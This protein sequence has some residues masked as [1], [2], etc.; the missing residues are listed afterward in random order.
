[1]AENHN[2]TESGEDSFSYGWCY[3]DRKDG[4]EIRNWY[5]QTDYMKDE[6]FAGKV[7]DM[8]DRLGLPQPD[9]S[10]IFRGSHH[11]LLFLDSHGVVLRIG[12]TDVTDLI[13]PGI[14]QPLGWLEDPALTIKRGGKDVPFTIAIYPGIELL[15]NYL[16]EEEQDRPE[17]VGTLRDIL[18][19]TGQGTRDINRKGNTGVIA[20]TDAHGK[21]AVVEMLLDPDDKYNS[22]DP[23][24]RR[25]KKE[26]FTAAL[27][28]TA[29]K[30]AALAITLSDAFKG[31]KNTR[32]FQKAFQKHQPLRNLF[33]R[34]FKDEKQP[35]EQA[36]T[37]FWTECA[38]V[39]SAPK[40]LA[41]SHWTSTIGEDGKLTVTKTDVMVD[42]VQLQTP[43]TTKISQGLKSKLHSRA[44]SFL[45]KS[46]NKAAKVKKPRR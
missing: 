29:D 3:T 20:I 15:E 27:Q 32:P 34:A 17:M 5:R 21:A 31:A 1:M 26:K 10:E 28:K 36:R 23:Q 19:E 45:H 2:D 11:D 4:K 46:I 38:A 22:S 40:K 35:D 42:H 37:A 24:K 44:L 41:L 14:L 9:D 8:L 12:P 16:K 33:W 13:N 39:T 7:R 6:P 43:W 18:Q 30:S 25:S